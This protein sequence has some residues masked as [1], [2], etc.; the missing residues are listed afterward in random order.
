MTDA[1][2]APLPPILV[3]PA[4][5]VSLERARPD[6]LSAV[7]V[8]ARYALVS[9]LGEGG[10][11]EVWLTRDVVIGRDVAMKSVLRAREGDATARAR[12][13]RE[14]RVQGQ[15]AHPS[16]VPVHDL[17]QG[18]DGRL[19]FT[20]Q[21]VRGRA[22]DDVARDGKLGRHAALGAMSRICLA[23]DYAHA[24]G[25]VHRDIKPSNLMVGEYGEVYV[26]D[27]GLAKVVDGDDL[28]CASGVVPAEDADG[29][30]TTLGAVLGT[31]GYMA[32]EQVRGGAV[33]ERTD[34]YALGACLFEVLAGAPLHEGTSVKARLDST[35]MGANARIS[36]RAPD[37]D[38]APELEAI[39]MRATQLDPAY[40]FPTARAM[41][42]AIDRYLEGDRDLEQRRRRSEE[43][44]RAAARLIEAA[45]AESSHEA[46]AEA[47]R[48]VGRALALDPNNAD[49]MK[50]LVGLLTRPP[51]TLPPEVEAQL[52]DDLRRRVDVAGR[53]SAVAFMSVLVS[54]LLLY[55]MGI[56][57]WRWVVAGLVSTTLAAGSSL[58]P[59]RIDTKYAVALVVAFSLVS[60]VTLSTVAGPLLIVPTL[61]L[62]VSAGLAAFPRRVPLGVAIAVG[63]GGVLLPLALQWAGILP[64][65]YDFAGDRLC[66][67]AHVVS[68]PAAP[69]IGYLLTM[70]VIPSVVVCVYLARIRDRLIDAERRLRVQAWLLSNIVPRASS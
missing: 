30:E 57:D 12:F 29:S 41:A 32:P 69:T 11:G 50:A 59:R 24:H 15:L 54:M 65:I 43:H 38:V 42:E 2:R 35:V 47:M 25:V 10:M 67:R 14:A 64:A 44:A 39:C 26:L 40:R 31:P 36:E 56:R 51:V 17:G 16:I 19:Y 45:R 22:L 46:R 66:I 13:L 34:V 60:L 53:Y 5:R 62:G 61:A 58:L 37:L 48:E 68:F 63:C 27:W 23:V 4:E 7:D 33:D 70:S 28:G 49:A 1:A 20:M 8:A 55:A 18:P 3:T 9:A 52:S 6:A 21:R